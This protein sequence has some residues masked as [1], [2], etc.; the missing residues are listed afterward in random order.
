[1]PWRTMDV[2]EQRVEFVV[3]A[4]R[5]SKPF[6]LCVM[7]LAFHVRRDTCGCDGISGTGCQGLRSAVASRS[8]APGARTRS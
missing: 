8:L 1:M 7:N 4:A 5:K 6:V 3:A 2:H